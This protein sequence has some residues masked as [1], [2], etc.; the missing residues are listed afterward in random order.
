MISSLSRHHRA[1]CEPQG[2]SA[3]SDSGNLAQS[4][5]RASALVLSCPVPRGPDDM[6]S[7]R[8]T[9]WCGDS[10]GRGG[11]EYSLWNGSSRGS[12]QHFSLMIFF[13]I[14]FYKVEGYL[15]S[16]GFFVCFNF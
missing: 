14:N 13:R 16:E 10:E 6:K 4:L 9:G 3:D 5:F 2:E 12:G 1:A 8:L 7:Q 11:M 15:H